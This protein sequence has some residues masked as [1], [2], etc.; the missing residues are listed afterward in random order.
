M[1]GERLR[2]LSVYSHW[3]QEGLAKRLNMD[4]S[5]ISGYENGSRRPDIETLINLAELFE[6]SIDYLVGRPEMIKSI[7]LSDTEIFDD[8]QLE[9]DNE[10]LS[11]EDK[12]YL[13][14]IIREKRNLYRKQKHT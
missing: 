9:I 13:L 3:T 5:T 1:L 8:I 7:E 14:A 12:Q 6:V 10:P 11:Y 4:V 2:K